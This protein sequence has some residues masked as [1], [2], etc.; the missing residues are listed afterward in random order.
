MFLKCIIEV[1]ECDLSEIYKYLKFELYIQQ[2]YV[3]SYDCYVIFEGNEF[4]MQELIF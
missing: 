3:Y 4:V 1:Y 2:L